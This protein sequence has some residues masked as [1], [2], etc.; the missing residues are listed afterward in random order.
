V[1]DTVLVLAEL[2]KKGE[3]ETIPE[4]DLEDEDEVTQQD[5]GDSHHL[6]GRGTLWR[7]S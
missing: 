2:Y 7:M 5:L 1:L 4:P 6:L 3:H